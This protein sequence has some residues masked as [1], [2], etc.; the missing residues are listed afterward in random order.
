MGRLI[1]EQVI[2]FDE[3]P[4]ELWLKFADKTQYDALW[5][6]VTEVLRGS[7]GHD[8]VIIYLEKERAKKVLP[9]TGMWQHR[10]QLQE[11]SW[12]K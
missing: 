4:K 2:P 3:V 5:P 1:C 9:P 12:G 6:A 10:Q 11:S 8:T 7:D